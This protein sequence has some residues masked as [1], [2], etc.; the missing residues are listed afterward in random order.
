M[1]KDTALEI[2]QHQL[3]RQIHN[4]PYSDNPEDWEHM[5]FITVW[6]KKLNNEERKKL[7]KG[8]YD[9]EWCNTVAEAIEVVGSIN[10]VNGFALDISDEWYD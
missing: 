2:L 1:R 4:A 7:Q 8:G 10:A 5:D 6:H 9:S 3:V